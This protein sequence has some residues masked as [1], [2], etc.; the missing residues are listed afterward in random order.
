MKA[1]SLG[2]VSKE[3]EHSSEDHFLLVAELGSS[4][5][6]LDHGLAAS[7]GLLPKSLLSA[8]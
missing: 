5:A 2:F 6:T 4:L 7:Q 3:E 8:L 1:L